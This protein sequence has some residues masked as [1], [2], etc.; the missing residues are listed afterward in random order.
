M[1]KNLVH[2]L[3]ILSD[4]EFKELGGYCLSGGGGIDSLHLQP[5]VYVNLD[6]NL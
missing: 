1:L 2:N 3:F 6:F 5:T 4:D